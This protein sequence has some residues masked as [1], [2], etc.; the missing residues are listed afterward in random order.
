MRE[1][2]LTPKWQ[3]PRE[4]TS[5][6]KTIHLVRHGESAANAGLPTSE[7]ELI[8][9]TPRGRAQAAQLAQLLAVRPAAIVTS[10]YIRAIDTARPLATRHGLDYSR[11]ALLN[12]FVTLDPA[13][14]AGTGTKERRPLIDSYWTQG[15]PRLRMGPGAETFMEFAQ[16]AD[17][18]RPQLDALPHH[19][20]VFGHGMWF[21]MLLWR[22][23]N[24]PVA[25]RLSMKSFRQ[26]QIGLPMPNCAVYELHGP[27]DGTWR[28]QFNAEVS[29]QMPAVLDP[30][31]AI[32]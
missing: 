9:L 26:F 8:P 4:A 14:V 11:H 17:D 30:A 1:R 19:T 12:E 18:Y 23:L 16:R 22:T 29:R 3:L 5:N 28:I 15:D 6:M 24:F 27:G 20:V 2:P 25:D 31:H 21:A 10:E 13:S 7:P 32:Q